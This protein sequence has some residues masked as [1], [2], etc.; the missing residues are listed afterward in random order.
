MAMAV[1]YKHPSSL[2]CELRIIEAKNLEFISTG[3]FFV[4]CYLNTRNNERIRLNS[5]R[6]IPSTSQPFWNESTSLECSSTA[7][8]YCIDELKQQSV[9]FELRWRNNSPMFGRF[10]GSKLLGKAEVSWKDV[11]ESSELVVQRWVSIVPSSS[12]SSLVVEGLKPPAL[13]VEMKVRVPNMAAEMMMVSKRRDVAL[14]RWKDCG[15][16]HGHCC[17]SGDVE[18]FALMATIEA[19]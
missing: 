10:G 18:L 3:K 6:E 2:N 15:C 14:K 9:V 1:P 19:F 8:S 17:N 4:R 5:T 7:N 12:S 13:H 11:L 16:R